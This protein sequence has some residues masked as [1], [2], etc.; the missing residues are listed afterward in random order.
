MHAGE[1]AV[2]ER[3][4]EGGPGWGSSMFGPEIPPGFFSFIRA[5]QMLTIGASDDLG[6]IWSSPLFGSPG[7]ARPMNDRTIVIDALP[8]PGDPLREA[9]DRERDIGV[10]ALHPQTRRRVRINGVARR[11]G[12]RLIMRTEQVLGNC[13]KYLQLTGTARIDWDPEQA[14][15]HPGALRMVEFDV[16]AVRQL[17]RVSPLRWGFQEYSRFNPPVR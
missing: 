14:K 4:D 16:Q 2:Q 8:A 7:F 10:L 1:Q 13:P 6:R 17:D 11:D 12:D 3:A 5:Q 15:A 9:F